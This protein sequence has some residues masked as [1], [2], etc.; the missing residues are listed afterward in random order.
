MRGL[1]FSRIAEPL[2]ITYD[3]VHGCPDQGMAFAV[4]NRGTPS[5]NCMTRVYQAGSY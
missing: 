5:Q 1:H 4:G 2:A 3:E